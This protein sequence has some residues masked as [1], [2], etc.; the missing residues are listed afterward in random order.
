LSAL[1]SVELDEE[2][3]ELDL[4]SDFD[5]LSLSLFS[6]LRLRVP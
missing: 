6:R 4:V 2:E 5:E 1:E 3:S